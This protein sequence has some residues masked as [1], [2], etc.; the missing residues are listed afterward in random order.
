MNRRFDY[1]SK[2]E[3]KREIKDRTEQERLLF[4]RW[5]KILEAEAG[6]ITPKYQDN[7]CGQHGEFLENHEVSLDA[8]F[9]VDGYGP[10]EVKF[11][12]P[13]LK[14][15]FHLKVGQTKSY[16]KQGATVLMVN[17]ADELVPDYVLL[18]PEVLQN[19]VDN[20]PV[21]RW[22][23]FGGKPSYRIKVDKYIWRP[24]LP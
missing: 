10:L 8:D 1:R 17:G 6:G 24:L 5:I 3:F 19:I 16:I 12:K 21:V 7:G 22:G 20:C 15:V 23:G 9:V 18:N 4:L 13:L 14:D 2:E 11:A